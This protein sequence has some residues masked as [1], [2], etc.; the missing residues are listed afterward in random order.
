MS[1]VT[2]RFFAALFIFCAFA[3]RAW[4][5]SP[6]DIEALEL[7]SP[8]PG[9]TTLNGAVAAG[10]TIVAVGLDGAAVRSLNGGL[11]WAAMDSL[12]LGGSAKEMY[13][14]A[15]NG[16]RIV[17]VGA[18]PAVTT[19]YQTWEWG[20][21]GGGFRFDVAYG[22]GN[23]VATGRV[24][25][26]V[27][28]SDGLSWEMVELP[29]G[30]QNLEAI[31]FGNGVFAAGG[32]G[33]RILRST[34]GTAWEIA[35]A[36][37]DAEGWFRSMVFANGRFFTLG[38][39]GLFLSSANGLDWTT[40]AADETSSIGVFFNG[41]YV[42]L[43]GRTGA[44]FLSIQESAIDFPGSGTEMLIVGDRVVVV[45]RNGMLATSDDGAQ[46]TNRRESLAERFGSVTFDSGNFVI[47]DDADRRLYSSSNGR[48]WTQRYQAEEG[49]FFRTN[50]AS[51]GGQFCLLTLDRTCLRSDDGVT[52][53]E[54]GEVMPFISDTTGLHYLNGRFVTV[55]NSGGV[56][57]STDGGRT[58]TTHDT[59]GISTRLTD[60]AYANGLYVAMGF[61]TDTYTSPDL[62]TWT[63]RTSGYGGS[64]IINAGGEFLISN[65][66]ATSAD[67]VN[68]T[69]VT[70]PSWVRI[71]FGTLG[72]DS[73]LGVYS[74]NS[75]LMY[76]SSPDTDL[77]EWTSYNFPSTRSLTGI[78]E[79]NGVVVGVGSDG[80][81]MVTPTE[82]GGYESWVTV[83]L[84]G[85]PS[86]LQTP[87]TDA[88]ADGITNLEEYA[89]GTDPNAPNEPTS[90]LPVDI[91]TTSFGPEV[92]WQQREGTSDLGTTLQYSD[93]M[94][95]WSSVG[96]SVSSDG[97]SWTGR[98]TGEAGSRKGLYIRVIWS[99]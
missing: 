58:W 33:G 28:S 92:S 20:D 51:G 98:V 76:S 66:T 45:G 26:V 69:P 64:E 99:L 86:A 59:A 4:A 29:A 27:I 95:N 37:S 19:D 81:L 46:W 1:T 61:S 7:R 38:D 9:A 24:S 94:E 34:N 82:A 84:D 55:G 23:F 73:E 11:D 77:T 48:F 47:V 32:A 89:R 17:A 2:P 72:Y 65:P 80:L 93:D 6:E 40:H 5:I 96:V 53:E 97:A 56:A 75:S 62:V 90:H 63:T 44:D 71:R 79:G 85:V 8:L 41:R 70:V 74:L 91:R 10:N 21:Y 39:N 49:E 87:S 88:D 13:G 67:G 3:S 22:N 54:T 18:A 15:T 52:W 60:I 68:W 50:I 14:C 78:A 36:G 31:A 43:N 35:R 42:G 57:S 12:V 30:T 25:N 16:S 83:N